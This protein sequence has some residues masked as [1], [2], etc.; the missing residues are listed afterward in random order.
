[1]NA[2][3]KNLL[4]PST[5]QSLE[6]HLRRSRSPLSLEEAL[7]RAVRQWITQE[8][9]A[10]APVRGYQWK[11][12]FLPETTHLRMNY[13]GESYYAKVVGEEIIF[14]SHAVTPRQMTIEIAGDGRNAWRDFWIRLPGEKS[15]TNAA[16]LRARIEN[17]S[18]IHPS[19]PADA[20]TA[21]TK[22]MS[23]T[24]NAALL[25]IEHVDHQSKTMSERRLP[26]HRREYDLMD[27]DH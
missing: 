7:D 10:A 1:M 11:S 21:A 15:W 20:M 12:L 26:K 4:F 22:A 13:G 3:T 6:D 23:D 2:P 17:K 19:S 24:L 27:D 8:L 25:L 16:L 18:V 14:R 5:Q 9:A